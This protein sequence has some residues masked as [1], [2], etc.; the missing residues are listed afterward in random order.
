[1]DIHQIQQ[2]AARFIQG[3]ATPEE[4]QQLHRWYD[5]WADDEEPIIVGTDSYEAEVKE[6]VKAAIDARIITAGTLIKKAPVYRLLK[7]GWV[8]AAILLLVAGALYW[9]YNNDLTGKV[10]PAIAQYEI[11]K[12]APPGKNGAVLTLPDGNIIVLDTAG[13]GNIS[14]N[15]KKDAGKLSV[16][17]AGA[18]NATVTTPYG[19]KQQLLLTDGTTVWLN[20]GSSVQFPLSFAGTE[21]RVTITGEAYFEVAPDRLRPFVVVSGGQQTEVLGTRFNI[22]AYTDEADITTTLLEGSVKITALQPENNNNS[23]VILKP[24]Q[25]AQLHHD[26]GKTL[27]VQPADIDAA[28]AWIKGYFRFDKD[29]VYAVMRQISRWYN[30]TVSFEGGPVTERFVGKMEQSLQLSE[31]LELLQYSG[32]KYRLNGNE[33][34]IK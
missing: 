11:I 24:G 19:R 18:G 23:T 33:L 26:G 12:D 22:N 20:A 25:Q 29:D 30:V 1:M 16:A 3:T 27:Q 28:T 10:E 9:Y 7:Y 6:R 4:E 21:R 31:V 8:A 17:A 14:P 15:F 32:I 34:I 5:D 13:D 2:L